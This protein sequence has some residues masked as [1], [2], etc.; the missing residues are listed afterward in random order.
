MQEIFSAFLNV[1]DI[2]INHAYNDIYFT[3]QS[4]MGKL[5][6]IMNIKKKDNNWTTPNIVSFSGSYNDLEPFLSPDGL[7]LFY[8]SNRPILLT[9]SELK[10]YDIWLVE[11]KSLSS[12]WS[13]PIRLS[14]TI[15]T[16]ANQFYP[17][18]SQSGNL[19]FTGDGSDSKGKD[20][21]FYSHWDGDNYN[22][23]ISLSS[24]INSEGYEF[25][26]FISSDERFLIY[27]AYNRED[28]FGSGDLYISVKDSNGNW[29]PSENLGDQINSNKMDYC[30]FI[31]INTNTLY[32]TSKRNNVSMKPGGFSSL[33][34]LSNELNR[35]D[36][37][38]SRLY[39]VSISDLITK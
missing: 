4:P 23:P 5:S 19:Y 18:V 20:D 32:F 24:S 36:N 12:P 9:D 28:G 2:T 29:L 1:R 16:K 34:E 33:T 3:V 15:N 11:R 35:Y 10:D 27:S 31:D 21:I 13:D 37:G 8:A 30:P 25:N 6:V 39:K 38:L 14:D 17:S 22:Y 7:Q 26:A